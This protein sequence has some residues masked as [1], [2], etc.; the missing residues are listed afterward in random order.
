MQSGP[1]VLAGSG[2]GDAYRRLQETGQ[3]HRGASGP[4][5]PL[6]TL[7]LHGTVCGSKTVMDRCF[8]KECLL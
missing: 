1:S 2:C 7:R 3:G 6:G 4:V 8:F 5:H